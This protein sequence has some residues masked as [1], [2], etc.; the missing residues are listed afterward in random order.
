MV[1]ASV[2]GVLRVGATWPVPA[3]QDSTSSLRLPQAGPA[4]SAAHSVMSRWLPQLSILTPSNPSD[5]VRL[6]SWV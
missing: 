2:G 3:P 5:M 6:A 4:N 1:R